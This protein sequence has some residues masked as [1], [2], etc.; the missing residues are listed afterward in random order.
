[1]D[2]KG[3]PHGLGTMEYFTKTEKKYKYEG[4]FEHG[5]CSG[6]GVWYEYTQYI[7]EYEPW[8]WAQMGE[9]DSAGRLIHPNT[10]PGPRREVIGSWDEKFRGW[11]MNDDAVHNIRGKKFS[12]CLYDNIGESTLAKLRQN[13]ALFFGTAEIEA[14][15]QSAIAEAEREA[16]AISESPLW[17]E[18]L[19]NYYEI[20]NERE[21]AIKAY[22]KC[23]INGYYAPIYDLARMY[24][25]DGDR[26]YCDILMK[27]G[28]KLGVPDCPME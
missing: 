11:W 8:E 19:G 18:Q 23:I 4:H 14:D 6:Y 12:K 7:R 25:E 26:E 17:I 2:D 24:M 27:L 5:V 3:R 1:M 9:Y 16:G 13:S 28:M 15:P 20:L 21:K 22:E 10:K